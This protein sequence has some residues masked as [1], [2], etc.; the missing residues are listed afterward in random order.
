MKFLV[1]AQLPYRLSR[2]LGDLGHD[3]LHTRDLAA[4]NRTPD[5]EISV[6]ADHD[7]RIVMTKDADF[8]V[9][10][11]AFRRPER[12]LLVSTGNIPNST[13]ESLILGNLTDLDHAFREA[14]FVEISSDELIVHR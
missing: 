12:L 8:V 14:D 11:I 6:R 9:S 5:L 4:G 1:D 3:V 2:R 13:R 7:G 10:H